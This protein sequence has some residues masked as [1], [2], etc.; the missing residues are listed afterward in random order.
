MQVL[1]S[2]DQMHENITNRVL[3]ACS[4][5]LNAGVWASNMADWIKVALAIVAGATTVMAFLNQY[6]TFVKNYKTLWVVVFV[7]KYIGPKKIRHRRGT[8]SK[9]KKESEDV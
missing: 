7:T 5:L 1:N 9:P 6:K 3:L 4:Y 2:N 8:I